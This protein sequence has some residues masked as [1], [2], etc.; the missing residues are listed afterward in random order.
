[1]GSLDATDPPRMN[2]EPERRAVPPDR[3]IERVDGGRP[4]QDRGGFQDAQTHDVEHPA[5]GR[6]SEPGERDGERS[7]ETSA[8]DQQGVSDHRVRR[9]LAISGP[10]VTSSM[11]CGPCSYGAM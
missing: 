6:R 5:N 4:G 1:M 2:D 3:F 8:A 7:P 11:P 10:L 9:S